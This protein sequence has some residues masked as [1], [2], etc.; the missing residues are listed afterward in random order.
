MPLNDAVT[1][2][3]LPQFVRDAFQTKFGMPTKDLLREIQQHGTAGSSD[4]ARI[5][6][7]SGQ[8][9]QI[10]FFD[11]HYE[12]DR[13]KLLGGLVAIQKRGGAGFV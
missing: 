5:S 9:S 8:I 1:W 2:M 13:A 12:L 4:P 10:L 7:L 3:T 11:S 6:E